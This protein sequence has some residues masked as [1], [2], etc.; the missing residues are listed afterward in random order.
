[1]LIIMVAIASVAF[2]SISRPVEL[3]LNAND[4]ELVNLGK[5]V[6][7]S[8]C[9]SCHG[10]NLEGQPDWRARKENEKLPAP[11]HD[12]TGHTWHHSDKL[13]IDL[14]KHG[15]KPVAGPDYKTDMPA[16]QN[17]LSDKEVI[18]VLSYIKSTW[19]EYIRKRHDRL[20]E[21]KS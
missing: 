19:P 12:E 17:I 9:A 7:A 1:M 5:K 20:N 3:S 2:W 18:A 4:V 10:V 11:P 21:P 6:Y 15:P 14:T 13:L 16:F 8:Q